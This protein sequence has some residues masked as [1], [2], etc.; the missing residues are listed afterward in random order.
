MPVPLRPSRHGVAVNLSL[1]TA[2]RC[3]HDLKSTSLQDS[4]WDPGEMP[5][6]LRP[7]RQGVAV[8]IS[9]ITAPR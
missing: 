5:V 9:L 8:N 2:P 7:S 6:P 1:I 3:H 4:L